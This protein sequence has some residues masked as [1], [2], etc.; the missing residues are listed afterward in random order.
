[1][2]EF[3]CVNVITV[4]CELVD[5]LHGVGCETAE[6]LK[7]QVT[8]EAVRGRSG[9][10]VVDSDRPELTLNDRRRDVRIA[11]GYREG[12]RIGRAVVSEQ[13]LREALKCRDSQV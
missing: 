5:H 12:L 6:Q 10:G 9:V 7:R 2:E 3:T 1:G 8:S 13:R 4:I 11:G